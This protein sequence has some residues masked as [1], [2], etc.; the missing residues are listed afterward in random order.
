MNGI[1]I[2]LIDNLER[3][4][5]KSGDGF[6]CKFLCPIEAC[7]KSIGC[8]YMKYTRSEMHKDGKTKGYRA[9]AWQFPN[10]RTH[11]M[12]HQGLLEPND[13]RT[14]EDKEDYNFDET[15]VYDEYEEVHEEFPDCNSN[16]IAA[17]R[18]TTLIANV[19]A[20]NQNSDLIIASPLFSTPVSS[21]VTS[22]HREKGTAVKS[23]IEKF[24]QA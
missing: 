16:N 3:C 6:K 4:T 5:S 9:A 14:D 21:K 22:V 2:Y 7:G 13:H 19:I 11:L 12:E 23:L 18:D 20:R 17:P 24:S 8:K 10:L 1:S 15:I